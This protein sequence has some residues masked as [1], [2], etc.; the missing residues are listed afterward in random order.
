MVGPA[1]ARLTATVQSLR[2]ALGE[3]EF[4]KAHA[5][6]SELTGANILQFALEALQAAKR[7]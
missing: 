6:G 7:Q 5:H 3:D 1:A 2:S 4:D